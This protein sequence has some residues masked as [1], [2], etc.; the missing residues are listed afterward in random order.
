ML[1]EVTQWRQARGSTRLGLD[2][3]RLGLGGGQPAAGSDTWR[4]ERQKARAATPT[5]GWFGGLRFLWSRP[6]ERTTPPA[7]SRYP[8][9]NAHCYLPSWDNSHP[10]KNRMPISGQSAPQSVPSTRYYLLSLQSL[11]QSLLVLM[12]LYILLGCRL[13]FFREYR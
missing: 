13:P 4:G 12:I 6:A 1:N 9:R 5:L 2:S 11:K 3:T 8:R 10:T 7:A